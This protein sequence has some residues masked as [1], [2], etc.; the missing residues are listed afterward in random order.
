MTGNPSAKAM[1][2]SDQIIADIKA[3]G[4]IGLDSY[5][6]ACLGDTDHGYYFGKDPFGADGDFTTA[7]EI[8]GLF[9]EMCGLYLAHMFEL[10]GTPT[11]AEIVELGPGRG[12]L[13][14]D[15]RHVWDMVMPALSHLPV[16][17][18][19]TSPSLRKQQGRT[20]APFKPVWHESLASCPD[21]PLFGIAN[22]F[23]DALPVR[24]VVWRTKADTAENVDTAKGSWHHR[25]VGLD[26]DELCFV[27]G[28]Q[29]SAD[30]HADINLTLP[31]APSEGMIA[32]IC[33]TADDVIAALSG[34]IARRG[35]AFLIIDYGRNGNGG[36]SLQAVADHKPVDV[37]HQAG[38]ADLSH[39]VDFAAL[40]RCARN[41][42]CRLIGPVPQGRFLMRIGLASRAEQAGAAADNEQRR[43]LLAAVDRLTSPA[44]MG[45]VFKVALL[46]PDGEG[47]PPG[48][49]EI[50]MNGEDII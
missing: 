21:A 47:T 15:M 22:E 7:P 29:L 2:L 27:D 17:L 30:E 6:A 25:L 11:N 36:D 45:E 18:V 40:S 35:G 50:T 46:V 24:Q 38:R 37:F 10:A 26:N 19:E 4:P 9:G 39:W 13:M 12:T 8:S 16:N 23:F 34:R 14:R 33:P 28:A 20:L 49:D 41:N 44:Q 48:F 3:N 5:M 31:E 32:E 1:S 43:A 42:G